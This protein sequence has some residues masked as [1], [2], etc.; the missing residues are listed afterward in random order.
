MNRLQTTSL[1]NFFG[2]FLNEFY[3]ENKL[4]YQD[5]AL[6]KTM[7]LPNQI[8]STNEFLH[9]VGDYIFRKEK[10]A[11]DLFRDKVEKSTDFFKQ[12]CNFVRM[13]KI[14][15]EFKNFFE[16]EKYIKLSE[17]I[18]EW[19]AV[20]SKAMFDLIEDKNSRARELQSD[21]KR[22]GMTP[23][24]INNEISIYLANY[25]DPKNQGIMEDATNHIK[26]KEIE[27]EKAIDDLGIPKT[28]LMVYNARLQCNNAEKHDAKTML[29]MLVEDP[30]GAGYFEPMIRS[31]QATLKAIGKS[32]QLSKADKEQDKVEIGKEGIKVNVNEADAAKY[33]DQ[34]TLPKN[35]KEVS[36]QEKTSILV[37]MQEKCANSKWSSWK[38]EVELEKAEKLYYQKKH[39]SKYEQM[40]KESEEKRL[41]NL[42][43][44]QRLGE[45]EKLELCKEGNVVKTATASELKSIN[46]GGGVAGNYMFKGGSIGVDLE[47][48]KGETD[49]SCISFSGIH[50]LRVQYPWLEKGLY[51]LDFNDKKTGVSLNKDDFQYETFQDFLLTRC[52]IPKSVIVGAG[53]RVHFSKKLLEESGITAHAGAEINHLLWSVKADTK[54]GYNHYSA[55][56]Q[57]FSLYEPDLLVV[58]GYE[59][60]NLCPSKNSSFFQV[61]CPSLHEEL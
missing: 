45:D 13:I 25:R 36:D 57:S 60:E 53:M 40:L 8:G 11:I 58:L 33:I 19:K 15:E 5:S 10:C 28:V 52:M 37:D 17:E 16:T 38:C 29:N 31:N 43:K 41:S 30:R 24:E 1:N 34:K 42:K 49:V 14:N 6:T 7:I 50:A 54:A 35:S 26:G 27:L 20:Y 9:D 44:F 61:E 46:F 3:E 12:Y 55:Q 48:S 23:E 39:D 59:L 18:R 32:I 22:E 47:K 2:L 21:L 4:F 56:E 51:E